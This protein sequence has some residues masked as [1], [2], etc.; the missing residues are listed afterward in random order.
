MK[1]RVANLSGGASKRPTGLPRRM[2]LTIGLLSV[3][4][5]L[6]E[7]GFI[8]NATITFWVRVLE[9]LLAGAY[10]A[11]RVLMLM[12][13]PARWTIVRQRQFEFGV[14][15]LFT[16]LAVGLAMSSAG[17]ASMVRFFHQNSPGDLGIHLL[18]LFLLANVL[19]QLLRLQH[20]L[21]SHGARPEWM[22]A[23]SFAMLILAGTLLLLLPRA[24]ALPD[25][26]IGLLDAFFTATSAS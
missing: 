10:V 25:K 14:L 3:G 16:L 8:V 19:V 11:D 13:G 24:S 21:L 18:K 22:L 20:R 9:A 12:R 4:T 6:T 1:P 15:A 17:A 2:L 23:G 5:L 26:P 7:H